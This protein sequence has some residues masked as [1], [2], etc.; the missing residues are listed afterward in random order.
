MPKN[1]IFALSFIS[2]MATLLYIAG[3]GCIIINGDKMFGNMPHILGIMGF[4]LLFVLSALIVGILLLGGPIYLYLNNEKK[5]SI[6]WLAHNVGL[7]M[8]ITLI[9][10]LILTTIK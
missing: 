9:V 10:L 1:K 6:K 5:N 8:A 2:S 7:M 4:L 3:V